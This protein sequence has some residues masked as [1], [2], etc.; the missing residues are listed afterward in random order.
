MS[1]IFSQAFSDQFSLKSSELEILL[2]NNERLTIH[3][4]KLN[5]YNK[6]IEGELRIL[7]LA[8]TLNKE[9]DAPKSLSIEYTLGNESYF[10]KQII[11]ESDSSGFI[12]RLQV[13]RFTSDQIVSGGG[14]GQP[15]FTNNWFIGMDYPGFYSR[16]SDN[17]KEPEFNMRVPYS[18]D[19]EGRDSEYAKEDGL[20][21][22]FHFPGYALESED[23]SFMIIS[24]KVVIGISPEPTKNAE[25][26][27]LDY[28]D[29]SRLKPKSFLHFNNWYSIDGKKIT[30]NDFVDK[31]Y[32]PI[33]KAIG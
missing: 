2:L 3:D 6:S 33:K 16:H 8:Y 7:R 26:A 13:L 1:E 30:I 24:K 21:T 10:R 31:T 20:V 29:Q 9:T 25:L 17:F 23:G 22:M 4:Y 12:D 32:L 15:L 27:L 28:I 18:I 5:T 19:L 14:H 11:V